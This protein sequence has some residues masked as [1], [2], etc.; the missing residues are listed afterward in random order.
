MSALAYLFPGQGSQRVGMG[1]ALYDSFPPARSLFQHAESVL[2]MPLAQLCFEGPEE[3]LTETR[4]AQPAI[5]VT[6][7]AFWEWMCSLHAPS[8]AF[9]A[10]HS[11][12][13]FS[14]LVAAGA[15]I[16]EDAL[17]LVQ[18]RAEA[19]HNAAAEQAGGMAAIIRLPRTELERVCQQAAAETGAH[20]GI[21]NDN[22]PDQLVISGARPA[23]ERAMELAK[24]A[25]ARRVVPLAVSGA[26]HS[27][28]MERAAEQFRLAAEAVPIRP[29]AI[30][31]I[32][33][34]TARPLEDPEEIRS[35]MIHQLIRPVR[36]TDSVGYMLEAGVSRFVETGPGSVLSGLVA[37]IA[38]QAEAW[39]IDSPDGAARLLALSSH[40]TPV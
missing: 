13:H 2:G 37:R 40:E 33:N 28:L 36:W 30:P 8:P 27:P 39:S 7:L 19:M 4:H 1:R 25:G 31:I 14:A 5:L 34:V 11:L 35:D 38:P 20:V 17:R 3:T 6:S 15:L 21:A 9:L 26:F 32:S 18:A 29:P 23:L 12:G 24:A 16:F 10:G 22:A